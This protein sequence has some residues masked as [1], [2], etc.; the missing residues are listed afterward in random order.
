M[1]SGA[2]RR[3]TLSTLEAL[4][5]LG[6]RDVTRD[7]EGAG[8]REAR[9]HGVLGEQRADLIHWAIQINLHHLTAE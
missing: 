2:R 8:E 4:H 5:E 9:G 3:R 6:V 1:I 7:D